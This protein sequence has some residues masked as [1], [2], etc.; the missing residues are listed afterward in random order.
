METVSKIYVG[1]D[2]SKNFLDIA[3]HPINKHFRV[4]NTPNGIDA[5]TKHL[6]NY[7]IDRIVCESS[8]GYEKAMIKVLRKLGYQVEL[9]DPKLIRYFILSKSVKAKTD[10]IDAKMIALYAAL[11]KPAY[12]Q[13]VISDQ[14]EELRDMVRRRHDFVEDVAREKKRCKQATTQKSKNFIIRHISYLEEQ[15]GCVDD[16]I[17]HMLRDNAIWENKLKI[18]LSI[19]GIGRI[20]ATALI[21]EMSELGSIENKQAASL[22]GVAPRTKQSGNYEGVASIAGGRFILRKIIY[23]AAL[24]ASRARGKF[25]EYYQKLRGKGK[26]PKVCVVALMNKMITIA[27][28]LI[29]KGEMWNPSLNFH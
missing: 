19:P 7:S 20:S 23:M 21:A 6:S 18:L 2:I 3:L 14:H 29:R 9:V 24:S 26:K 11:N 25:S 1:V 22:L 5:I 28:T 4:E 13:P 8:G 12:A 15:I 10:K 17:K 27:N 16:E